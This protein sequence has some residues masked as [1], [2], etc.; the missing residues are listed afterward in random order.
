MTNLERRF[1]VAVLFTTVFPF[2]AC[3]AIAFHAIECGC[4]DAD[5]PLGVRGG[6]RFS[7]LASIIAKK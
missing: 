4:M 2:V 7:P 1:T 3:F 5:T 6:H